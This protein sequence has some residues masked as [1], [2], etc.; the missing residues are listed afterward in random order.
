MISGKSHRRLLSRRVH[1]SNLRFPALP[2]GSGIP[3]VRGSHLPS[4]SAAFPSDASSF[5]LAG[6][7]VPTVLSGQYT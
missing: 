2:I 4:R 6:A 7:L 3:L 5:M 1:P